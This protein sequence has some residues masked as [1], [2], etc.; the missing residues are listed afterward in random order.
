[1]YYGLYS[2]IERNTPGAITDS[3]LTC[4]SG[5]SVLPASRKVMPNNPWV[6]SVAEQKA[7]HR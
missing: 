4:R 5:D 1:M 2:K 3:G 7:D 6:P